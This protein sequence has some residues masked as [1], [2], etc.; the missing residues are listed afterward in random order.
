MRAQFCSLAYVHQTVCSN[1]TPSLFTSC[2][3][4]RD[5]MFFIE[6]QRTIAASGESELQQ[7]SVSLPAA[8]P[9]RK[10]K[11]SGNR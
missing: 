10:Q 3:Q 11:K 2:L 5:L 1:L 4:V 6:G 8:Q 7:G 9:S